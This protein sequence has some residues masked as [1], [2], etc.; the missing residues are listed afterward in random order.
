M[1]TNMTL[2]VYSCKNTV[3]LALRTTPCASQSMAR[4]QPPPSDEERRW[5]GD[6]LDMW[7]PTSRLAKAEYMDNIHFGA[8]GNHLTNWL[9][10]E[11]LFPDHVHPRPNHRVALEVA[12]RSKRA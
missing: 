11:H 7:T 3:A 12:K 4:S 1:Y 9:L 5:F 2:L 10:L 6:L 8:F